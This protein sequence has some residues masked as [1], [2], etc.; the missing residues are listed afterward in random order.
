MS[1]V[2]LPNRGIV[3]QLEERLL[4]TT[5]PISYLIDSSWSLA[6]F[7]HRSSWYSAINCSAFSCERH[8]RRGFY[9]VGIERLAGI[10]K[11]GNCSAR[12]ECLL[13]CDGN[14]LIE[15]FASKNEDVF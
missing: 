14:D 12:P 11:R 15:R 9:V 2:K 13:S 8:R 5:T 1:D 10:V 3:A 6:G 4:L 7:N